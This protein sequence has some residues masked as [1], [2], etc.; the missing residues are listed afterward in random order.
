MRKVIIAT[1]FTLGFLALA[2]DGAQLFVELK[3]TK[4]HEVTSLDIKTTS[5]KDPSKVTD[6]A[7]VGAER[8][9]EWLLAF[10]KKEIKKDDKK[11]KMKFKGDQAQMQEIVAWM[12]TL[13]K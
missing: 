7:N 10:L 1:I 11:H 5:K 6:L 4:C 9:S 3:C 13:K 8:D 12:L 2:G